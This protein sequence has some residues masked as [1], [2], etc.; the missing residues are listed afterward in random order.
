M[1]TFLNAVYA[2]SVTEGEGVSVRI[3]IFCLLLGPTSVHNLR[4]FLRN[5]LVFTILVMD[6]GDLMD[7]LKLIKQRFLRV[8]RAGRY[9][10]LGIGN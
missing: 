5:R 10:L 3:G 4:N 6:E 7:V 9:L 1:I 2:L 8:E